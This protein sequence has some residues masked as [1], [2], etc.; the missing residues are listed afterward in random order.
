MKPSSSCP[1]AASPALPYLK[2]LP[3]P[4][5][6]LSGLEQHQPWEGRQT[7]LEF[8]GSGFWPLSSLFWLTCI[9]VPRPVSALC[10]G[11]GKRPPG[12]IPLQ[13]S[14]HRGCLRGHTLCYCSALLSS[15]I[16]CSPTKAE[17]HQVPPQPSPGCC[18]LRPD[19]EEETAGPAHMCTHAQR[20][21]CA[22]SDMDCAKKGPPKPTVTSASLGADPTHP[23]AESQAQVLRAFTDRPLY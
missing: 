10:R 2:S 3:C 7:D 15:K 4:L 11:Q 12:L 22:C 21:V 20:H 13:D 6:R 23:A 17:L 16:S 1:P 19:A 9:F 8:R 5:H 14:G 18:T